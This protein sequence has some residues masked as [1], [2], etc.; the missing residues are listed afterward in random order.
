M[1]FKVLLLAL[2][3]GSQ[4]ANARTFVAVIPQKP[5]Q[6]TSVWA[7]IVL[8][9][10]A[11]QPAL[12]GDSIVMSYNPGARDMAGPN[13]FEETLRFDNNNMLVSH[14]GN[15]ISYLQENV[16]Y[17]YNDYDLVCR[18]NLTIIEAVRAGVDPYKGISQAGTSGTV[19]EAL[20]EAMLIGGPGLTVDQYIKV[21]KDNVNWIHGLSGSQQHLAFAHGELTATRENPAQYKAKVVPMIKEG[22]A[23]TWFAHGLFDTVTGRQFEDM[24]YPGKQFEKVF[25]RKWGVLPSGPLYQA[26]IMAH[27][28][29]DSLQKAIWVNKGNPNLLKLRTAC[30]QMA[31][32]SASISYLQNKIGK[33]N[34]VIGDGT[35]PALNKLITKQALETL[36]RFNKEALGLASVY[37]PQL[38]Q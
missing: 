16:K 4:V 6:G 10:L 28:W 15:A 25:Y 12:K 29:R 19:P 14:G 18:Q 21:F 22:K 30:E 11:K 20:A 34:W 7:D 17:N 27:S 3:L 23:Y 8:R 1:K 5:G 26:Y 31:H 2:L 36:V 32:N 38:T 13:K 33:Y 9:E 35:L 24:N 37:K